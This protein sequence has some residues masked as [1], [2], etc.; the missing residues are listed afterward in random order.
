MTKYNFEDGNET[1][2]STSIR[3]VLEYISNLVS[4]SD[5]QYDLSQTKFCRL[6]EVIDARNIQKLLFKS[7]THKYRAPLLDRNTGGERDNPKRITEGERIKTHILL[8]HKRD[9]VVMCLETGQ[10]T[11]QIQQFINYLNHFLRDFYF[12]NDQDLNFE[13][14]YSI[15]VKD[16]FL[17]ELRNL[18]RV[19]TG[20][21]Y[22][23][24]EILGSPALNFSN[25][26]NSVKH[27]LKMT[28]T[29]VRGESIS[30]FLIDAFNLMNRGRSRINKIR[31]KGKNES[32]NDVILDTEIIAK[33][34]FVEV[35]VYPE[36]GEV[37]SQTIFQ[38]LTN[39]ITP[40]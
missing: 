36:T 19:M 37:N 5:R 28:I 10:G 4:L 15:I 22:V 40:L 6:E 1:N 33:T 3:D 14:R 13:F 24:K 29:A 23:D 30:D 7:A 32:D 26:I 18:S 12:S 25:R 20:E 16:N 2:A 38:Q 21:L 39:I 11:L 8:K 27:D 35:E 9:D 34:E 17:Q 31:V